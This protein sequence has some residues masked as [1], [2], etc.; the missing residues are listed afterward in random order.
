VEGIEMSVTVALEIKAKPGKADDI[1]EFFRKALP[2]HR[3]YGGCEGLTVHRNQD[4]PDAF[5]LWEHWATRPN[6]EA[7]L[8]W[9]DETGVLKDFL[10]MLDGD[11]TFNFYDHVGA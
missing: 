9:R 8:A 2:E 4:D 5:V 7:Y 11:P 10:D 1:I 3:S 6:Y